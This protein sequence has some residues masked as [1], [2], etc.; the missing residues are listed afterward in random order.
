M[1]LLFTIVRAAHVNGTHHKLALDALT[2][3][4]RP[5]AESWRRVFLKHAAVYL[6]G[7]KAPDDSFKDFKN[8][9]L[10]V[11][12]DYWGGAPE[13]CAAWYGHAIEALREG[14]MARAVYA[15]GVLS[16]YVTDPIHPFHTA[17]SDAENAI[18]RAAEWSINRAY[19]SL[20]GEARY[21]DAGAIETRWGDGWLKDHV[22]AGAE[23]ANRH[24]ETLIAHYDITRGV[25]DPPQG[26]DPVARRAIG[27]L[28][29]FA[30]QSFAAVLDRLFDEAAVTPPE[31]ALTIDTLIATLAI[32]RKW[33]EKRITDAETRRQ[34]A[35]IYDELMATG[36]VE[37][38]LPEDDRVVRDLHR[39]EVLEPRKA[40]E[41]ASRAQRIT[42]AA[43]GR[44]P[45]AVGASPT[46][47]PPVIAG[48]REPVPVAPAQAPRT[49]HDGKHTELAA[50]KPRSVGRVRE[51]DPVE[52]APIIGPRIAER[53]AKIDIATIG[54]LLA[55]DASGIASGLADQRFDVEEITRWQDTARLVVAIPG[56][57]GGHAELLAGTGFRSI[58]ALASADPATL[59]ADI[60]RYAASDDGRRALRTGDAPDIETIT[61][62]ITSA[63]SSAAA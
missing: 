34:V 36:R 48:S 21:A 40:A 57:R 61:M 32:P 24:Y 56:L 39:K 38:T 46:M 63:K 27:G 52:A 60:L 11:R 28:I 33:L 58:V 16:H 30:S 26:L 17:Q 53:L 3:L 37:K 23:R 20:L 25:S 50:L 31:V 47:T 43:P 9:V 29:F 54:D 42:A 55:A 12:D 41:A 6:E 18:H 19:D 14:D 51:S 22:I 13:K 59:M 62:W 4:K 5:D 44:R 45:T 8:H 49:A 10:H 15:A 7:S 1:S 35:A 2:H